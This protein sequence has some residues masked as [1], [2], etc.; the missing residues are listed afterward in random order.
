MVSGLEIEDATIGDGA[1]A[2]RG[3]TVN[4]RYTSYL[5]RGE[6]FH[7]GVES[8]FTLGKR[9]VIAGLERGVEGMRVGGKRKL[10]VSPH[11]AYRDKGVPGVVPPNAKL[12][13]EVHLLAV[14]PSNFR[15]SG[16]DAA[17]RST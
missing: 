13:F 16:R 9:E 10:T 3:D 7:E 1:I 5:N 15:S 14:M 4:I 12:I 6:R 17:R 2:Q 8:S 11:L